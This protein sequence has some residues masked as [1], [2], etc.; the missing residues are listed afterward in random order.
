MVQSV[1]T[2]N[3]AEQAPIKVLQAHNGELLHIPGEAWLL[4]ADFAPQGPDLLLTGTDNTQIL[5]RDYFNLDIPPDLVTDGGA[6]ISAE[7]AV[8][9]A[10]PS[11]PGQFA[12]L[13]NGPFT[14]LA[15]ASVEPI[16]TIE[17]SNGLVEVTRV[18]GT[19]DTVSKG[20]VIFQGD[21]IVTSDSGA[22]GI[23]FVDETTF[24]LGQGGRMVIDEM[25]Y[26]PGTQEGSFGVNLV[27][28]VF[29]FVS[30]EIAKTSPDA[31]TLTTPVATIGIRGTKVAGS[32]AQEGAEN[33]ISLL[34]ETNAQGQT[35]VGELTVSNQGGT[36][37]L[38]AVGATVQM[39]SSFTTPPAPVIFSPQQIQQSF[40]S[41]LTTLSTTAAAKAQG[42]AANSAQE[43]EDAKAEAQEA[44]GEA[45]VAEAEA[46][47][48]ATEAAEAEAEAE[49]AVAEAEEARLE[50][51]AA[52][53]AEALA[54]A[55]AAVAD[56]EALAAEAE[57]AATEAEAAAVQA[58][59]AVAEAEAASVEAEAAVAEAEA[60]AAISD[61]AANELQA[62]AE[63]Y[64][65]FGGGPPP[66]GPDGEGP[67]D[68]EDSPDGEPPPP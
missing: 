63:A 35:I 31:M 4:K 37:T 6:V 50:A 57:V 40:G 51:E 13:E 54:E 46:E 29:T 65:E 15:Q 22:V 28:G 30:G 25:V 66:T 36:V 53:D 33:T 23:V 67:P 49:A 52:G 27:Q 59:E 42:D 10:G 39:S 26:D 2:L 38:N 24:S 68:G 8:K 9:L 16:G 45:E 21:T 58:E 34:P 7:L 56:A 32:A 48:A 12:L 62:Q 20:D 5:I 17:T 41:A 18:D 47:A 55:E 60:T 11:A 64:A 3:Y 61:Q 14:Q 1:E 19:K 44:A 43:A